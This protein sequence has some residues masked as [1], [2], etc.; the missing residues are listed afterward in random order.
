MTKVLQTNELG[1]LTFGVEPG[2]TSLL[3]PPNVRDMGIKAYCS[4]TCLSNV[5][6]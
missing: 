6:Y 2:D 3:I 5:F 4:S 1:L